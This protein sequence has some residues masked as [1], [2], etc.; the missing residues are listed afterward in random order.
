MSLG[1]PLLETLTDTRLGLALTHVP[2]W[3]GARTSKTTFVFE[4]GPLLGRRPG[5]ADYLDTTVATS[6][7]QTLQDYPHVFGTNGSWMAPALG[8]SY[9][10]LGQNQFQH[11]HTT[12]KCCGNNFLFEPR[13]WGK[14]L[15]T[16]PALPTRWQKCFANCTIRPRGL[17]LSFCSQVSW[18]WKLMISHV[19]PQHL[20]YLVL[21]P[22]VPF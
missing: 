2:Y 20:V 3:E 15:G 17:Y 8:I 7:L 5:K 16:I 4:R 10:I 13:T 19:H 11:H 6:K 12:R 9:H 18:Q 21:V 22:S 1:F 14:V